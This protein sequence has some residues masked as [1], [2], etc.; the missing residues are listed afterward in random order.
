MEG[1]IEQLVRGV[2]EKGHLMSLATVDENGP[3]VSDLVYVHD[4]EFC[5]Y[6]ISGIKTRHSEALSRDSRVAATITMSNKSKEPNEGIQVAGHAEKI[7]GDLLLIATAYQAKR[8]RPVPKEGELLK[9]GQSWYKL[10]PTKIEL[11]YEPLFGFKKQKF[12]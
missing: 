3:W 10:T 6:W 5:L 1:D 12:K 11:I 4:Q 7:E 8:G 2:F 9:P